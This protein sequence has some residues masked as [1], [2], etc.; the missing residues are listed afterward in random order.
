MMDLAVRIR[1]VISIR[2]G[3]PL[4]SFSPCA[5]NQESI[6]VARSRLKRADEGC[7]HLLMSRDEAGTLLP[8]F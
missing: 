4:E 5:I 7:Q 3:P 8:S 1:V 2:P 6:D